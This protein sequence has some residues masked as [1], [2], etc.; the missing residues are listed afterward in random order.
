M[1]VDNKVVATVVREWVAAGKTTWYFVSMQTLDKFDKS[2]DSDRYVYSG[3]QA[4]GKTRTCKDPQNKQELYASIQ[5]WDAKHKD[6]DSMKSLIM[7]FTG[8]VEK[9]SECATGVSL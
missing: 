9:T 4:F 6:A 8:E 2:T 1:S 5:F 7:D 3:N